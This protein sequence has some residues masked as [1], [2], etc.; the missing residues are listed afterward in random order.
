MNK[1][2]RNERLWVIGYREEDKGTGSERKV[3]RRVE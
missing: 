2:M 1:R 3:V